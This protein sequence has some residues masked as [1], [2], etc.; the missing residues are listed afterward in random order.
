MADEPLIPIRVTFKAGP[1]QAH[2]LEYEFKIA[3]AELDR[4][5]DDLSYVLLPQQPPRLVGAYNVTRTIGG[6]TVQTRLIVRLAEV[7]AVS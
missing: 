5:A 4:L 7:L 3:R 6:A 1:A 2:N